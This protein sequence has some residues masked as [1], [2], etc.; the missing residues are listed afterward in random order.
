MAGKLLAVAVSGIML[1]AALPKFNLTYFLWGG[2]LPFLWALQGVRG[3][4]AFLLGFCHGLAQ[5]V[6]M[7]YWIIYVTVVYGKLPAPVGVAVLLLLAGYLSLFRGFWAWLYAWG[8]QRGLGGYWWGPALWVSLEFLQ[9]YLFTGFPWMLL[10]YGLHQSPYML[11]LV[12]ITGVYGL[13]ALIILVNIAIYQLFMGWAGQRPGL[14]PAVVAVVCV[15]ATLAY[16]YIRLPEVRRQMAQSPTVK[17][18]VVQGNIEQ[19]RKWDPQYQGETIAIYGELTG[20]TKLQDPVLVVW[21]ETAAPFF[22]MREKD[23]SS[24]VD[25]IAR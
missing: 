8:E 12:D 20:K 10:G 9:A 24:R 25:D 17:V 22:Y 19:G 21:P 11:Q 23:L 6:F 4:K 15:I 13:S 16:G 7:L 14:R 5:N 18:A 2:L 3:R 1:A